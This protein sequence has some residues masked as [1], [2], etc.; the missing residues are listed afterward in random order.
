MHVM[1]RVLVWRAPVLVL[2]GVTLH[3]RVQAQRRLPPRLSAALLFLEMT[4][5][6]LRGLP[7]LRSE[8]NGACCTAL[9]VLGWRI[10][11]ANQMF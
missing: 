7:H 9:L 5:C 2:S 1:F 10:E 6:R 3:V 8:K 11:H 4:G